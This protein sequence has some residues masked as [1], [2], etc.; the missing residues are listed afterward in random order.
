[1]KSLKY[2]ASI[3][4]LSI[5][6]S[7][8]ISCKKD[9]IG[10]DY[11]AYF[12]GEITNPNN[13]YVLFCRDNVVIDTIHLLNDNT[14]FKKFDSLTPGLYTFKHEPEY[15]Y[16]YFDKNDSI[17]VNIDSKKFDESVVFCGRGDEKNNFLME[18][19]LKNEI[20]RNNIFDAFEYDMKKFNK[21]IDS[22][23]TK[24]LSFYKKKKE[25]ILWNDDF[26]VFAKALVDFP[27]YTKKEIY[28]IVHQMRTGNDVFEQLPNQYYTYRKNVD[29]NNPSLSDYSPYVMYINHMLNNIATI[30][31]HHHYTE[32]DL[33]LKTNIRKLNIADTLIKNQTVKNKI[34]NNIA[35]Q[36]LLEDQNAINNQA[37]LKTYNKFSTDKSQKN[38]ILKIGNSIQNLLT[39]KKL[40]NVQLIDYNG[41]ITNSDDLINQNTVIIFWSES[42][43]S[44]MQSA[45][46]K[47]KDF[48]KKYPNYQFIAVNLDRNN[49]W[50]KT[51]E[52]YNYSNIN[53][54]KCAD[55]EDIKSKWAITK[56]HRTLVV[57]EDKTIKNAFSN[58]FD[59]HFE[60]NL[61]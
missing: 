34:L 8:F 30:H 13:R 23:Y 20:D 12:G 39:G 48:I 54:Y 5:I 45:H 15:Q 51:L 55:F 57:H 43:Y 28:P 21:V 25:N 4:T 1:M 2:F 58:I 6:V 44:H 42:A 9:F 37:F 50:K 61:K 18:M 35:F 3:L 32:I 7:F 59:V 26:D 52:K 40:P 11:V 46:Q 29:Y 31:H 14:F 36:Y 53:E 22:I 56:I 19:Y 17:M 49:D 41:K 27:Y 24:N 60:D 38:E 47:I 16:V 33:A 10:N